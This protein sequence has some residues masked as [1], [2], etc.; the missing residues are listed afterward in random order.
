M[1]FT[2]KLRNRLIIGGLAVA[3]ITLLLYLRRQY[4]LLYNAVYTISGGIIHNLGLDKVKM[5]LFLKIANESDLMIEISNLDLSIYVNKMF[6]TRIKRP[7]KQV[8]QAK[9]DAII[10]L[11]VEFN[12]KDLLKAGL[13]NIEP[14]LYDNE[15]L[16]ITTKGTLS[17][18]TGIVT[19]TKFPFSVDITLKELLEPSP[20]KK[21]K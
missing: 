4:N 9:S 7:E 18:K 11:D 16:V 21:K 15:K 8:I 3:G 6:I 1:E 13:T 19:L 5:T 14:I 2:P 10:K 20:E 17:A 12:P